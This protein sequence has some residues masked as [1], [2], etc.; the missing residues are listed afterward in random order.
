[1]VMLA[2]SC[3]W[4]KRTKVITSGQVPD[5]GHQAQKL[6]HLAKCLTLASYGTED[7]W[8]SGDPL[9][10][11]LGEPVFSEFLRTFLDMPR[12]QGPVTFYPDHFS[13]LFWQ[14]VT[15]RDEIMSPLQDVEQVC[16]LFAIKMAD[17]LSLVFIP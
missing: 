9:G 16:L 13:G 7:S 3:H 14:R 2:S 15:M 1:M 11:L 8:N 6:L 17:S 10:Y 4:V 5:P 12:T